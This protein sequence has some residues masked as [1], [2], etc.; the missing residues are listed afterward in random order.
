MAGRAGP[1]DWVDDLAMEQG[2]TFDG[3]LTFEDDDGDPID[4]TGFVITWQVRDDYGSTANIVVDISPYC[5]SSDPTSGIVMFEVPPS[6]TVDLPIGKYVSDFLLTQGDYGR[7]EF[8][9]KF[10]IAK[11]V[12]RV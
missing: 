5:T 7:Y 8:R 4:L 11:T 3:R 10:Q 6:I 12:S 2:A 1:L 9:G